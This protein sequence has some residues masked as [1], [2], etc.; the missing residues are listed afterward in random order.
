MA[1]GAIGAGIT[2]AFAWFSLN[3][4]PYTIYIFEILGPWCLAWGVPFW[5]SSGCL[6]ASGAIGAVLCYMLASLF[7]YV[8]F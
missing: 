7:Y 4:Y 5:G 2:I 6:M 3:M 8:M 1:S